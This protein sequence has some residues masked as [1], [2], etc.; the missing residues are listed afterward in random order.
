[1]PGTRIEILSDDDLFTTLEDGA[2]NLELAWHIQAKSKNICAKPDAPGRLWTF[3]I[4]GFREGPSQP[5]KVREG[6]ESDKSDSLANLYYGRR[7]LGADESRK[8]LTELCLIQS[9]D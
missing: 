7:A 1:V 2:P 4:L 9:A 3:C 8:R 5:R 6:R